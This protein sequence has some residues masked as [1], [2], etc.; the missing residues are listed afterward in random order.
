MNNIPKLDN[1]VY[2][3]LSQAAPKAAIDLLGMRIATEINNKYCE[4]MITESEAYSTA[5]KDPISMRE[6]FFYYSS[7]YAR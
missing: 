7:L 3:I 4:I 2:Q 5:K 6:I 1:R